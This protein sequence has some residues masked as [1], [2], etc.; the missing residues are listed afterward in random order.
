MHLAQQQVALRDHVGEVGRA[1]ADALL[2]RVAG[3]A[4]QTLLAHELAHEIQEQRASGEHPVQARERPADGEAAAAVGGEHVA[5]QHRGERQRHPEEDLVAAANDDEDDEQARDEQRHV[6]EADDGVPRGPAGRADLLRQ[7]VGGA[8]RD[9][10]DGHHGGEHAQHACPD[11]T[12]DIPGGDWRQD[13][14]LQ[15]RRDEGQHG[16][17]EDPRQ[18]NPRDGLARADDARVAQQRAGKG[19]QV[20][21]RH[22]AREQ[23]AAGQHQQRPGAVVAEADEQQE[24]CGGLGDEHTGGEEGAETRNDRA[25]AGSDRQQCKR[26]DG[27]EADDSQGQAVAGTHGGRRPRRG[28]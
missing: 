21:H 10:D 2:E 4:E 15:H 3:L 7:P 8:D 23:I 1:L 6:H 25:R 24:R 27:I 12:R 17:A 22:R 20:R 14:R 28:Q 26:G 5:E 9:R 16:E 11:E 13:A 19:E 18:E